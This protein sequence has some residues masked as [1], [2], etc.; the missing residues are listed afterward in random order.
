LDR[1]FRSEMRT[2]TKVFDGFGT[3][4]LVHIQGS[5]VL[6]HLQEIARVE[7]ESTKK[8]R[9][10]AFFQKPWHLACLKRFIEASAG[11]EVVPV[12]SEL[13][14]SDETAPY[15][16][17]FEYDRKYHA[18]NMAFVPQYRRGSPGKF[19]MHQALRYAHDAG[20]TEFDLLRGAS[21]MKLEW[22]PGVRENVRC[23]RFSRSPLG[24]SLRWAVF[25][26]RPLLKNELA[27]HCRG[28]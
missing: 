15:L 16:L 9:G 17:G 18:Y 4:N 7:S 5:D 21:F 25:Q 6:R 27:S 11:S 22:K 12:I 1:K 13:R 8:D 2:R 23:V 20:L 19:V 14:I 10:H 24:R 28:R 3:W 26:A